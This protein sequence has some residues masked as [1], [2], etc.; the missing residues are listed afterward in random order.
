[1]VA[2]RAPTQTR[3]MDPGGAAERL[4]RELPRAARRL[5][6][7]HIHSIGELDLLMLLEADRARAWSL[8]ELCDRLRCPR[9]WAESRLHAM[10]GAGLLAG[11][12]GR[13]ACAPSRPELDEALQALALAHRDRPEDLMKMIVSPRWRR[14][15]LADARSRPGDR[16]RRD[17][18]GVSPL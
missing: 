10:I 2:L 3:A 14:R 4:A 15:A 5:L 8:D 6:G 1:M 18:T 17:D 13:Y 7:E 12:E 16:Q 11:D 9:S